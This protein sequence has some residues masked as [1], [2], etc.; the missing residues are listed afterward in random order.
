MGLLALV[1]L[2][3][4]AYDRELEVQQAYRSTLEM[5]PVQKDLRRGE[6]A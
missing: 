4:S 5:I 3:L 2:C 1:S 6:T